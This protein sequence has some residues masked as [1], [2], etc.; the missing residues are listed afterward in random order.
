[1]RVVLLYM[2]QVG[3]AVVSDVCVIIVILL[4]GSELVTKRVSPPS[5][6][7]ESPVVAFVSLERYNAITL[8][9]RVHSSLAALNKVL[10]G[11][12]L[13]TPAVQKLASSLLRNEVECLTKDFVLIWSLCQ[14][15]QPLSLPS[16]LIQINMH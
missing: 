7:I 11:S 5:D 9:Q 6:K 2:R 3:S 10:R 14:A 16:P 13:L 8:V 1:M 15:L 12:S 4:Q